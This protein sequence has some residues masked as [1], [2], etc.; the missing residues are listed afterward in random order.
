MY[1]DMLFDKGV[2]QQ[3]VGIQEYHEWSIGILKTCPKCQH[4]TGVLTK[5][6]RSNVVPICFF[7][8]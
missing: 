3:I 6:D 1:S 4:L 8:G 2:L 7:E 5:P